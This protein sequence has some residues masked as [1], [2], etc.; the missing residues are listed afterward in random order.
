M[1]LIAILSRKCTPT[2]IRST[3]ARRVSPNRAKHDRRQARSEKNRRR[4]A[5]PAG[6]ATVQYRSKSESKRKRR[7]FT[8][9]FRLHIKVSFVEQRQLLQTPIAAFGGYK[10]PRQR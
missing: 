7:R 1:M 9:K 4:G 3:Q 8:R 2:Y 6:G 5:Q 10:T